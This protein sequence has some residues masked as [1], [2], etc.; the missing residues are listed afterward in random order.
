M[1]TQAQIGR[2]FRVL[3]KNRISFIGIILAFLITAIAMIA[4]LI[5]DNPNEQHVLRQYEPPSLSHLFGTDEYGRDV[6]ARVVWGARIS[7]LVGVLSVFL[8]LVFG[9][10]IGVIGGYKGGVIDEIILRVVDIFMS[11]PILVLG[12]FVL[13]VMGSG[14]SRV[15][16]AIA[17]A[18]TPR[19]ARLVRGTTLSLKEMQFIQAARA[20]GQRDSKIIFFHILP[21]VVGDV[22]VMGALWVGTAILVESSLSF[23]G[24]G[25]SPPTPSWGAIIRDGLDHLRNAPHIPISAGLAIF[26]T[27]FSF[28]LVADGLRDISDPKLRG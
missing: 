13:A 2:L 7:L 3:R 17:L 25:I 6:F 16:M 22:I 24:L 4:P 15:I 12:L 20:I 21:N 8:A 14:I 23:V 10:A 1:E 11:F 9:V 19:V 27:V 26:V 28:N 5:S 18:M